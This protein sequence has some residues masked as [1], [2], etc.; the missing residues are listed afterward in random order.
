M[1]INSTTRKTNPFVGNG[2]AHTFPFSFKV[3]TDADIVVKKLE[4]S[5]SIETTLTLGLNNDY[6]VSLHAD[7]NGNPGGEITL[8]SGGNNQNL[9]S[10]FSIVITSAVQSLQGTDLTNQ[11]GF[12][13][14]VINDALDKSIILHQQQQTE[15]D[16]SIRFSL[17]NTIG[18]LEIT[19]NAAARA[20]K[21]LGFD[22]SGEFNV[23]QELG[24]YRGDW[25]AGRSYN[26]RDFVKDTSTNN[27]FICVSAHTSSGSQPLTTNTN[28][29]AWNLIVDAASATTSATNAA[30]SATAA[31][32]SATAAANSATAAASSQT[33]AASSATTAS[34]KA[35]QADTAKTAAQ[36]AQ[37]AAE[38]AKTAAETALDSFDDRYLGAKT[39]NPTVDNDGNAL[40]DGALYFNTTVNRMRVYDLGNTTWLEVTIAGTDL[41]NT[42]TVAGAITNVNNVGG[43]IANVNAVGGAI[44]NV[45][46]VASEINNNKL[47]TVANNIN[48]V[49]TA[50]DDLNEAT[51]EIDTVATNITNV[52]LVGNNISN[53]NAIGTVL[54]GQT[55]FAITVASGVFYVDGASKPTINLIRGY[56]YIFNQADN[57]NSGHPL[58][59][60]DAGGSAYTTGVT[61]NG[62]AGQANANVT[63]VVPANAPASLRYYCTVHGNNMGNTIA[64]GDDNIGVVASNIGNV[65]TV[66]GAIANVNNV[67]GSIANVNT[68][69][70]NLSGV[71]SFAERYRT[72]NSGNNPSTSLNGGD[73]FFNQA[74]G[75]LLVYNALTSAWE[76]TQSV[77][78]FFINTIS[79][80]SGTGGNSAT[81]NGSAYKFTL[82]NAG[83][84]AQQM[85]VS[86]NGVVQKP[87]TGT[88]QPSEGFALDGANIVFSSPPPSGADFFI[89]TIGASVSIGTPSDGTVTEAKLNVSNNPVNGYFLQ[90][91]S[92]AAGGLTWAQVTTDLV[93]DTSPQLGGNLDAN[94]NSIVFGDSNND[95]V[96]SGNVNRLKFGAGTDMVMYHNGT[97]NFIKNPNGSFKLFTGA[98]KQ[99]LIAVPD[100]E[101]SLHHNDIKVFATESDGISVIGP[102]NGNAFIT[103]K[104][105]EGDDYSDLFDVGVY[106]GGPFKIQNKKS[107]SWEDSLVITG[108]AGTE[109]FYNNSS[110]F[111]TESNGA[112]VTGRLRVQ[113]SGDVD[114]VIS[115]TSTN[116]VS[117]FINV[118][119]AGRVEYNCY[120][121]GVGTK[122]PHVF[123]GYT[124]E[125]ARIDSAGIKFNG[126]TATANALDDYEE[127]TFTATCENSVTLHSSQ[128]LCMYTKVGRMVTI[129]GQVRVNDSN[130]GN[131]SFIINNAP[132]T[133]AS[134][135][136]GSG[137]CVGAV[138]LWDQN[139]PSDT[140]NV[141][142]EMF[143]S[144]SHINF[145]VNRDAAG[146]ERMKANDNAYVLFTI[147][148]FAS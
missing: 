140:V 27:I 9:A 98:D 6:I 100:G 46:T 32:N 86:I 118:K 142:V 3:F 44:A 82:S 53:I 129:R 76:E 45:N 36:T 5:T 68:V 108:D 24:V 21:V 139:V 12:F 119:T 40:I 8:K 144:S 89:V 74:S 2:S 128:D 117:A 49:V 116:A 78:N 93:G 138:R 30:S 65:N 39:S 134:G 73:L 75:K 132:F 96:A 63:F 84:F 110:K 11:G 37:T 72:D 60:K 115:D 22:D 99:S 19:E 104:A 7:Q 92:S 42:N 1:T 56:T 47:Q 41:A 54:A 61:V 14:E 133:N 67:G 87:N 90:A 64:V 59:F 91:Q 34:T 95:A 94:S 126:D 105:D 58:A 71:N 101:V 52:N 15:L 69:A 13:P 16:R 79:S 120:K 80:F 109:L 51:S 112:T 148:Y 107:G 124:E 113:D 123:V 127:G 35:T 50:A 130:G 28:S 18:S 143:G 85:L 135:T 102:E 26:V 10:G 88:G 57:S 33:A 103:F 121:T 38:T 29:S 17:T 4:A 114:L 146:A 70:S 66:G 145:W 125:Y 137:S 25:A 48:A 111:I 131:Q 81:F 97:D 62:T 20:N 147:T 43:S 77:G 106:N 55:T 83:Q 23:V 122:Y 31:A 141:V 136:D